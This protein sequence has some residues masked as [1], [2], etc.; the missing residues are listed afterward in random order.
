[1]TRLRP[2]LSDNA[3]SEKEPSIFARLSTLITQPVSCSV[4]ALA[5]RSSVGVQAAQ[6]QNT[7][8]P[9]NSASARIRIGMES[10]SL[11][12]P[13]CAAVVVR[14]VFRIQYSCSSIFVVA[15]AATVTNAGRQPKAAATRLAH[16]APPAPPVP[17]GADTR[18]A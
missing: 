2:S 4:S 13:D 7:E 11:K 5:L 12:E 1:M 17:E 14:C 10:A 15:M 8:P 18:P 16:S 6:L 9:A 3:P